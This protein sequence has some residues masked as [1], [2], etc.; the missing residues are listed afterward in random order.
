[1]NSASLTVSKKSI[2][3]NCFN[4]FLK[5]VETTIANRL[6]LSNLAM[7]FRQAR[8]VTPPSNASS[9]W[10]HQ[11][12]AMHS[13]LTYARARKFTNNAN[14]VSRKMILTRHQSTQ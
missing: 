9:I 7:N 13:R 4:N 6:I 8:L 11:N 3:R 5:L 1:M 12:C 14:A 2:K 10:Q